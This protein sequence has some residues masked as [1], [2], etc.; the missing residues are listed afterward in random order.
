MPRKKN[1][2]SCHL[3]LK[4][5]G[6]CCYSASGE[7]VESGPS[8]PSQSFSSLSETCTHIFTHFQLLLSKVG[9]LDTPC[10]CSAVSATDLATIRVF[11]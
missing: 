4:V 6:A 5:S 11:A 2:R 7:L 1:V 10:I 8:F 3:S 9:I